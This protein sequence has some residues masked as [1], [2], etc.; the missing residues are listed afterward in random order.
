MKRREFM[1]VLSA[2]VMA[3]QAVGAQQKA[4]T[5]I[6]WLN[7]SSPP[8]NMGDLVRG[9]IHQGLSDTGFVEGQNMVSEYRWAE[10]HYDR[11]PALAADLVSRKVDLIIANAGSPTALAAKSATSTIP[12]VFTSVGDPVGI[13][14][15]ASLARPGGNVTG[16]TNIGIELMPKLVELL[17]ELVPQAKVVALLVNPSNAAAEGSIKNAQEAARVKGIQ[18]P[19]LKAVTEGEIDT[20]FGSLGELQAGGLVV[21]ADG[22]FNSG[23]RVAQIVALAARYAVPAVYAFPQSVSAGGLISYGTDPDA[24]YRQAGI[25]AGRILKGERP[26]DL[27]V[28]QPTIFK[29]VVNLKTAKTL[30]LTVPPLILARADEVIE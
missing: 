15:V 23:N 27:P 18:L 3:A 25:Y 19:V 12:I 4:M 9:R 2:A 8:A 7:P 1:L 13:G 26:A 5:I 6:G 10:F 22:F 17:T 14:L 21:D 11:L 16:F 29:L 28:Q 24:F 30:G 20:A